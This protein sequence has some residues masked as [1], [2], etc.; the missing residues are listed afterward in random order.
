[1]RGEEKR[2]G[3]EEKK[4]G[5]E[6]R[7]YT[8]SGFIVANVEIMVAAIVAVAILTLPNFQRNMREELKEK[9][10]EERRRGT[11]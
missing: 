4:R 8:V 6:E 1:M 3:E 2:R 11:C 9:E 10:R 5:E 7:T